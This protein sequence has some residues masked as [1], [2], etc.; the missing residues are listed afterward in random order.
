MPRTVPGAEDTVVN[1]VDE[2]SALPRR[3][4][5]QAIANRGTHSMQG[6][7]KSYKVRAEYRSRKRTG[8]SF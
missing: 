6:E 4:G 3:S 5:R 2:V 7:S 8:C 1:S